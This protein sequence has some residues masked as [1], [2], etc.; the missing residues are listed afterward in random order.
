MDSFFDTAH[1]VDKA[2]IYSLL[3]H[4]DGAQV[5]GEDSG[6]HH[7]LFHTASGDVAV[8]ANEAGDT[9]LDLFEVVKGLGSADDGAA[10]THRVDDHG[11]CGN[12]IRIVGADGNGD[13]DG[14]AAAKHKGNGGLAEGGDHLRYGKARFHI[15]AH[16]VQK[17][18]KTFYFTAVLYGGQL[19]KDVLVF[20]CFGGASQVVMAFDFSDDGYH[21]DGF[22]VFSVTLQRQLSGFL[23]SFIPLLFFVCFIA[24]HIVC[25]CPA[26]KPRLLL[27][28]CFSYCLQVRRVLCAKA[29]VSGRKKREEKSAPE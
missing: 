18:K 20:C 25:S 21:M 29:I 13:A 22:V 3:T 1:F 12:D 6:F 17:D 16:G 24:A 11:S 23:D 19:G 9:V 4:K 26:K 15:A 14:M 2:C 7:E 27:S 8:G 28:V 5:L 10:H